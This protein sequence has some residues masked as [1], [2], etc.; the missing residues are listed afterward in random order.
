MANKN[1]DLNEMLQIRREKLEKL[2]ADGKNPHAI[3]NFRNR[4]LSKEIKDNFEEFEGKVVRVAGRIMA[5]RGHG[6]MSFMDVQDS[7]GQIQ[8]VNRKNV[9]GDNFKE[10]KGYDI[11]DLIGIEGKVFKT[12]QGEVSIET[13]H[14][15]LL[16]KSLQILPEKWHGLKDP[17]IRYRQRYVDLIVNPEVKD[18]FVLRSKIISEIRRFLENRG[19]LEVETPI[20]NTIAGGATARPFITH[21]NSLD[22]GMYLRIASE[23]YLKRLIV[24][25]F[26]KVYEIGRMFRNEGMDATHNPEFTTMELYQAYGDFEDMMEITETMVEYVANK[27]KGSTVVEFDGNEIE[28]KA[29]WRRVSMIDAVKEFSGVDFNEITEYEDAVKIA[30]EKN[31]EVKDSRGEIIAEFFDEFVEE[32][33]I[34]PTF[35]VDYPVEISPLAK[36]KNDDP[37]LTYRFEA[38]INGSEIANAFSELNDAVDQKERFLDQVAKREAG[39]DEAQM[40]DYDFVNALEVGMPPTGGLGIGI[41]RLIMILTGQH[42]IR[43]VLLFPTMKPIGEEK[44]AIEKNQ[45]S[46]EEA[47]EEIDFTNV[48]VEDLFEDQVDFE[49]F[50]KSDFRAVKVL[51]CKEVPKSK[52]LLEFTLDDGSGKNRTILSGIKAYYSPEELVGKTLLAITNLPP[53][54]MMGID[55]CGMI[56]SAIHEK[57]GEEKLNLIILKNNIPA[58]AKIY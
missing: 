52:K 20:L 24:G 8:V 38:F 48:V 51:D 18:V 12:N 53:R 13:E 17:D 6:N 30:K 9:M 58:G 19:F 43:D 40:M 29:P 1:Q 57:D 31:I 11:G 42:S 54:K 10:T 37:S 28:L 14:A 45:H 5:R 21:H 49:T 3:V 55:S 56:L 41:D 39:D 7:L 44:K 33:L 47:A 25:G 27:V 2:K 36:R 23:L 32:K 34:Q 22:I 26:D 50:S 4:T 46:I 15:D 35:I 16:T